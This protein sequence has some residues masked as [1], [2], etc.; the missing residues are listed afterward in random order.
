MAADA[1]LAFDFVTADGRFKTA[2][3]DVNSDLFWA[4]R[5]GG[6]STFGVVTSVV[7]KAF[8]Q[9]D[10]TLSAWILGNSTYGTQLVSRDNFKA[11]RVFWEMFPIMTDAKTY[12]FFFIFNNNGQLSFDMKNFFAPTHTEKSLTTLLKPFFDAVTALGVP[13]EYMH[14]VHMRHILTLCR[15]L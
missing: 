9:T 12:S 14:E 15:H 8:P 4:L 5:G 13:C 3:P 1:A 10:V 6:G 7:V 11:I 2:S